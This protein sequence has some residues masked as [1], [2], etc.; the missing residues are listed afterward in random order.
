MKTEKAVADSAPWKAILEK[1][2]QLLLA[3]ADKPAKRKSSGKSDVRS[4]ECAH[5]RSTDRR[6]VQCPVRVCFKCGE[7]GH[8]RSDCPRGKTG[9]SGSSFT[10]ADPATSTTAAE[11]LNAGQRN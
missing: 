8:Y 4:G 7:R 9:G 11:N 3:I 6:S 10:K 5:C 2:D 1:L